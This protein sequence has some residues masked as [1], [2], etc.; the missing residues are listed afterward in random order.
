M[1]YLITGGDGFIGSKIA[2]NVNGKSFDLKS[3]SD[4]FDTEKLKRAC[5]GVD[6][7]FHCAAKISVPESMEKPKEYFHI[8]VDGTK[9]VIDAAKMN[10]CKIVFSSSAAVYGDTESIVDETSPLNPKSP[11]AENKRDGERLLKESCVPSI[12]LRYFNVYGPGQSAAYAGVITPFINKA[13]RNE[14][15]IIYG[16]GNQIR[17]FIFVDDVVE[18]NIAATRYN[19]TPFEI[20]NIAS[21]VETSINTLAKTIITLTNSSS[22]IRYESPRAGDILYSCADVSNARTLLDWKA[23]IHLEVGLERTIAWYRNYVI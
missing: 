13:L 11:Y 1:N 5:E 15:L 12:C 19:K 2:T 21:G 17:D 4:I 9:A 6:G 16:D 20:F 14:D 23:K 18:A 10:N 7:I 8:N 22:T 3:G